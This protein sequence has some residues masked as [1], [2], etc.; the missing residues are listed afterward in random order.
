MAG[1]FPGKPMAAKPP[2]ARKAAP[3]VAS[4]PV[5][6]PEPVIEATP[7]AETVA[8]PVALAVAELPKVD[9]PVPALKQA[10][11]R[12][13]AA[14]PPV[15]AIVAQP[16]PKPVVA[17]V[18]ETLAEVPVAPT[19][20]SQP[21]ADTAPVADHPATAA[22]AEPQTVEPEPAPATA[23]QKEPV[24]DT[25]TTIENTATKAETVFADMNSRTKTA[26]E[27]SQ[28]LAEEMGE[29]H[30]GNLEAAVESAKIYAK[31][32]EAMG[33]EAAEFGRRSFEQMTAALKSMAQ[34]KT[35]AEL[36]KLH[37]DYV[38]QSFDA[39]VA[40]GSKNTEAMIKLAGDVAQ[41]MSNRFA[42]V[43]EKVKTVA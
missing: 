25:T 29:F 32:V 7:L 42:L 22:A 38:R 43:A 15:P 5:V 40:E 8:S 1:K 37:A 26:I 34:V 36:M 35:P 13:A 20:E 41:P 12:R 17:P 28:K 6:A 23:A 27:K 9:V 24:M 10:P 18:T 21:D 39:A 3:V 31:G 19:P 30:K 11:V 2:R 14:K 16:E 4:A 33:Q